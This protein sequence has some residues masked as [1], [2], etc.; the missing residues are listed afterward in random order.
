MT[1]SNNSTACERQTTL[2]Q[3]MV[4]RRSSR[5]T[6]PDMCSTLC[7]G[8]TSLRM[9][10]TSPQANSLRRSTSS[11]DR[12]IGSS[13]SSRQHDFRSGF[14][15]GSSR[16]P[17][18]KRLYVAQIYDHQDNI[19]QS[20]GP[21]LVMDA[22]DTYHLQYQNKRPAYVEALWVSSIGRTSQEVRTRTKQHP[23]ATVRNRALQV[24]RRHPIKVLR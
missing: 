19:G 24:S 8:R 21:L 3:S 20:S 2:A 16:E 12:S 9:A 13:A 18:G 22:W 17:L 11:S 1:C 14:R 23:L 5:S 6:C 7:S 4:S 10:A 15:L